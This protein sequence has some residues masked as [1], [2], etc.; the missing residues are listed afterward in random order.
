METSFGYGDRAVHGMGD[1][2]REVDAHQND[3][4]RT[5][6]ESKSFGPRARETIARSR[7]SMH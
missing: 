3:G 5:R 1:C 4:R 6:I 2:T 7:C